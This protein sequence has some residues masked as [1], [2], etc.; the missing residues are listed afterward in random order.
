[1]DW[2]GVVF[3]ADAEWDADSA[4]A[5]EEAEEWDLEISGGN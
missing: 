2:A 5:V 4:A 1:M 3:P